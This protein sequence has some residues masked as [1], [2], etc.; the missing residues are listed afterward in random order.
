M[1]SNP[2]GESAQFFL[3][4]HQEKICYLEKEIRGI[5]DLKASQYWQIFTQVQKSRW[6]Q[7][8]DALRRSL[9]A[10]RAHPNLAD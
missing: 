4:P 1:T 7:Q 9:I 3:S 2:S 6:N 10:H 5:E 8:L